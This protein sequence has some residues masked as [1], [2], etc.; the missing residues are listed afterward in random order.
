M[1]GGSGCTQTSGPQGLA[2]GHPYREDERSE[3]AQVWVCQ[4]FSN[5]WESPAVRRRQGIRV[6]LAGI[7][8]GGMSGP[9]LRRCGCARG[10]A[11]VGRVRLY[12]DVRA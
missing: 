10:G 11:I 3:A 9:K 1:L 7:R 2:C 4:G 6:C 12:A 8:A 5:C